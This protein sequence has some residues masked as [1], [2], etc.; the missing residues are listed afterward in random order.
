MPFE[1]F[2]FLIIAFPLLTQFIE[3]TLSIVEAFNC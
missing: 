3:Q 2:E 1:G